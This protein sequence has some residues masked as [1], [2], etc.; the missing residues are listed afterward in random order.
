MTVGTPPIQ[1]TAQ[2][3]PPRLIAN[4]RPFA[5]IPFIIQQATDTTRCVRNVTEPHGVDILYAIEEG[6]L[7]ITFVVHIPT[8]HAVKPRGVDTQTAQFIC[9]SYRTPKRLQ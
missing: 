4:G 5:I 3:V 1:T 7:R 6:Q 8:L 2:H 9:E